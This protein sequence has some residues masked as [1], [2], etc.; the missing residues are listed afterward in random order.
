MNNNK[1]EINQNIL[2]GFSSTKISF[3][4]DVNKSINVNKYGEFKYFNAFRCNIM[5]IKN[6]IFNLD[7]L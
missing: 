4:S 5:D 6:F 3:L 1:L 7:S 2:K